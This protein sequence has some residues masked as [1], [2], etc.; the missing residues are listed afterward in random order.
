MRSYDRKVSKLPFGVESC[1]FCTAH[2]DALLEL[3]DKA[4]SLS[5]T[6]PA[7]IWVLGVTGPVL[8]P[9]PRKPATGAATQPSGHGGQPVRHEV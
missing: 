5:P 4:V 9:R 3:R 7:F 1:H 8:V 2:R 6:S